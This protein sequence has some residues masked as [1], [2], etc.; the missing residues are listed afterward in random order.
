MKQFLMEK[1]GNDIVIT[2]NARANE[3][4]IFYS[5]KITAADLLVKIKNQNLMQEAGRQL[6]KDFDDIG[7]G[8]EDSFCDSEDLRAA[9]EKTRTPDSWITLLSSFLDY[10]KYKLFKSKAQEFNDLLNDEGYGSDEDE[11]KDD[12]SDVEDDNTDEI[13]QSD[14]GVLYEQEE[15]DESCPWLRDIMSIRIHCLFQMMYNLKTRGRKPVPMHMMVGHNIYARDRSK[16]ILTIFN[17]IGACAGY[18]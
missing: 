10:P 8:L 3:S 16:T 18:K 2:E 14:Q 5:S 13:H 11:G 6:A 7:F 9:W 4:D 15:E 17:R 1:Y 12:D